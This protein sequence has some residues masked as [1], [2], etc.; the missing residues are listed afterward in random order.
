MEQFADE[1]LLDKAREIAEY[2]GLPLEVH[3]TGL[4]A[5]ETRLAALVEAAA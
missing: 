4:N 3:H 5:L 2:L 1:R